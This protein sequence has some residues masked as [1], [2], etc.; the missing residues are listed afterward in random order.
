MTDRPR[1]PIPNDQVRPHPGARTGGA[2]EILDRPTEFERRSV[3]LSRRSAGFL[4]AVAAWNVVIWVTFLRNLAAD[5]DRPT[6]FYVAHGVITAVS[7]AVAAG[8]AS[9]GWR[10]WRAA[11][12]PTPGS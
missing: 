12:R 10:G 9:L 6:S 1:S 4:L 8:I 7:L 2:R 3:T 11:G 5:R